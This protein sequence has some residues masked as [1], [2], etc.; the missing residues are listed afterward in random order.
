MW[1]L[2]NIKREYF[3]RINEIINVS[4]CTTILFLRSAMEK[5]FYLYFIVFDS[6][7][8]QYFSFFFFY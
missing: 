1:S 3:V 2:C 7:I 4:N 8:F 6:I 5:I